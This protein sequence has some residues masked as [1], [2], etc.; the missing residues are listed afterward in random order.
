V[1]EGLT[2]E[3]KQVIGD[4]PRSDTD[5]LIDVVK[6]DKAVDKDIRTDATKRD[7]QL[8]R[9][10]KLANKVIA[11]ADDPDN[12]YKTWYKDHPVFK[13]FMLPDGTIESKEQFYDEYDNPD[14]DLEGVDLVKYADEMNKKFAPP[15]SSGFIEYD[16]GAPKQNGDTKIPEDIL[17]AAATGKTIT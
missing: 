16:W 3:Q 8:K 5:A 2:P 12:F 15:G 6:Q 14:P 11:Y 10:D 13:K 17:K 4:D 1:N 9:K 7:K